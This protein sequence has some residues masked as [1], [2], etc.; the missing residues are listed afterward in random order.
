VRLTEVQLD[1]D[2]PT[3]RLE[4]WAGVVRRLSGGA[5]A[6]RTVW[7]TSIPAHVAVQG[8]GRHFQGAAAGHILQVF[9]TG[10]PYSP[11]AAS[12]LDRQLA[13]HELPFRLG[14]GAFERELAPG[15][16]T[17]HRRWFEAVPRLARNPWFRGVW[18]FPAG[19][20]WVQHIEPDLPESRP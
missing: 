10:D 15:R 13:R 3:R 8:Y 11:E 9:D 6:G 14:V 1:Y 5:L 2:C 18:V 17:D 12:R 19:R 4:R 16:L 7:V 20:A